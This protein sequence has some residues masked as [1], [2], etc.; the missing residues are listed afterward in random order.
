MLHPQRAFH[1]GNLT[2]LTGGHEHGLDHYYS[3]RCT[4]RLAGKHDHEH[5][6]A[7]GRNRQHPDRDRRRTAGPVDLCWPAQHRRRDGSGRRLQLLEHHLGRGRQR[8]S[9]RHPQG[10]Q[11]SALNPHFN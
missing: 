9:D 3:G 11:S 8:D 10:P 5:Q 4:L 1:V 2:T 7:T 6:R